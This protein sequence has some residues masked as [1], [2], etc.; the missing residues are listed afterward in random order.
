MRTARMR[1][2]ASWAASRHEQR[3]HRRVRKSSFRLVSTLSA[4]S[5]A[6]LKQPAD[7]K[8]RARALAK[9]RQAAKLMQPPFASTGMLKSYAVVSM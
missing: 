4:A 8:H 3:A 2:A 7:D 1:S 6:R 5:Q 9:L